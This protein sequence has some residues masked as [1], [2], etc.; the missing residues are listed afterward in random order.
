[1]VLYQRYYGKKFSFTYNTPKEYSDII[2]IYLYNDGFDNF[3]ES[4]ASFNITYSIDND[5][6]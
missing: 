4:L 2:R 1:M 3:I 6:V 5:T